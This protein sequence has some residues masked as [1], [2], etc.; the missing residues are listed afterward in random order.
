MNYHNNAIIKYKKIID[1]LK[2]YRI[3]YPNSE[4]IIGLKQMMIIVVHMTK[5]F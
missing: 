3:N 5:N 2:I 4:Q 1:L